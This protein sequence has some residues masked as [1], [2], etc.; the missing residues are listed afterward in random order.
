MKIRHACLLLSPLIATLLLGGCGGSS[1]PAVTT[2][3]PPVPQNRVVY[4]GPAARSSDVVAFKVNLWDNL[5]SSDRCGAC[6]HAGGQSPEFV[7]EKDINSAYAAANT[8]VDLR[9]PASSRMVQKVAGG[10]NCWLDDDAAC[11]DL[12]TTWIT[13]WAGQ[14]VDAKAKSVQ[15]TAPPIKDPGTTRG[16]PPSPAAFQSHVYP[17]VSKFCSGCHRASSPTA[18]K[19]YFAAEDVNEAYEAAKGEINLNTPANSRLVERLRQDL[20]NCWS[21]CP[22]DAQTMEDA[23]T[24]MAADIPLTPPSSSLVVSK[25]LRLHDGIL[26]AGGGRV[27]TSV[28]AKYEF[29]AGNGNTAYDTSG[30]EPALN[31]TL[32]NVGWV[33]GW[34]LSFKGGD[35]RAVGSTTASA[36]LHD[37]ITGSGEFSIEAWVVPATPGQMDADIVSYSANDTQRNVTLRQQESRYSVALRQDGTDANGEPV[38]E[39]AD[40]TLQATLQHIVVT[41]DP[42][43]GRRVYVNGKDTGATDSFTP[44]VLNNWVNSYAL[45]LGNETSQN[46]PWQG[47]IRML[48][49][50]NRALTPAQVEQNFKAGVGERYYL[51]FSIGSL[52]GV[53]DSYIGF[54]VSRFD[55]YSYLFAKPFFIN[56]DDGVTPSAVDLEGMRLGINGH[57]A[58]AGQAWKTLSTT[59]GGSGYD[60]A[61]QP[62]SRLGTIIGLENGPDQDEFFLTFAKLGDKSHVYTEPTP[63][64]DTLQPVS[65]QPKVGMRT[66]EEIDATMS[67]LTGVP[68]TNAA[69]S[70]TYQRIRQQLPAKENLGTFVTANQVAVAQLAIEYCNSMVDAQIN[71]DPSV[72]A[73]FPGMDFSR[74][75]NN[76]S[77][78]EWHDLVI[79]PLVSGMVS[80]GAAPGE[81][82]QP[83]PA[84]VESELEHLLLTTEDIKP[85]N[86]PDGVPDGLA[87]CNG[88]CPADQTA[89]ATKAACAATL[90][91]ATM[92]LQ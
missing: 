16:F 64:P 31:L 90:G 23:I 6:H 60:P 15:F 9:S 26:A 32:H 40:D 85:V 7:N 17:I 67:R 55:D 3:P 27:D 45:V 38:M 10:H 84:D 39:T 2:N 72:P 14:N 41:Y 87:R 57:E 58:K 91:S 54:H 12:I 71:N 65:A 68:R 34:G 81:D 21:N 88:S 22:D 77:D 89:V 75:A 66:F 4:N 63:L 1:G 8:V 56:L 52:I 24:A 48:A 37:L 20:H 82:S 35:S 46:H 28:I 11:A 49:I 50:H 80:T 73:F 19:P 18:I 36:K 42:V 78:S 44:T 76:I 33:G 83:A 13:K 74:N 5:A 59:I 25:A 70:D 62:L 79:A 92:L 29:R 53:P 86:N 61:G 43:N 47:T 69:V 30:V 51:L